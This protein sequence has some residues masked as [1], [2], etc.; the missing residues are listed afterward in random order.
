MKKLLLRLLS[1]ACLVLLLSLCL[2]ACSRM[3]GT[4]CQVAGED[5]V[6]ITLQFRPGGTIRIYEGEKEKGEKPTEVIEYEIRDGKLYA[7]NKGDSLHEGAVGMPITV[8]RDAKGE[9]LQ[10]GDTLYYKK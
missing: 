3:R 8:G 7:W 4:Y 6:L 1:A 9:Y 2:T 5:T 10:I